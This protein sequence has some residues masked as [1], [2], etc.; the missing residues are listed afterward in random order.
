[1]QCPYPLSWRR[2]ETHL[3]K[4]KSCL[5]TESL[6]SCRIEKREVSWKMVRSP[7]AFAKYPCIPRIAVRRFENKDATIAQALVTLF[8]HRHRVSDVLDNV[9]EIYHIEL[10]V[11]QDG[12]KQA[13]IDGMSTYARRLA[14]LLV[15]IDAKRLYSLRIG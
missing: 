13:A 15:D 5:R 12:F 8:Y 4:A 11:E 14:H 10:L 2:G 1:V 9:G 6:D 3:S 7:Q